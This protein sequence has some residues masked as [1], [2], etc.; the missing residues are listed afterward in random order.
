[1][2]H[3]IHCPPKADE[4][5]IFVEH[6]SCSECGKDIVENP[7]FVN[8]RTGEIWDFNY[9][10]YCGVEMLHPFHGKRVMVCEYVDD[11]EVEK[12]ED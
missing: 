5:N 3:W 1:M 4:R 12:R 8:I 10:P 2:A 11:Q 7:R 9:C 6:W